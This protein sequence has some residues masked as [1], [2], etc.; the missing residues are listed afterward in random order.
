MF[1]LG[2][3]SQLDG[4]VGNR[5]KQTIE[6]TEHQQNEESSLNQLT[7]DRD[8]QQVQPLPNR[9]RAMNGN[10][11]FGLCTVL[12]AVP[13]SDTACLALIAVKH[14]R[15]KRLCLKFSAKELRARLQNK[16]CAITL[17]RINTQLVVL[18]RKF[19]GFR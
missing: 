14:T 8:C 6:E 7:Q 16:F 17:D 2:S 9:Q 19:T 4:L 15:Y 18:S 10:V 1:G 13:R 11:V 12:S 3:Y 5:Q